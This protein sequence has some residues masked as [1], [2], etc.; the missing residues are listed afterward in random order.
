MDIMTYIAKGK[1]NAISRQDLCNLM[2]LPDRTVRKLIQEARDQGEVIIN[3]QDGAG[4]YTSDN[5]ED[6][7]RQ[8]NTNQHR[9]LSILRQQRH[10]RRQIEEINNQ[11]QLKML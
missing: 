10:I 3:A 9:A 2:A 8:Y 5:V 1:E 11:T 7:E 6:L 4:Y